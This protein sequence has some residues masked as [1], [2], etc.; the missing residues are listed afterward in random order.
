MEKYLE[1]VVPQW[2]TDIPWS[3]PN[4]AFSVRDLTTLDANN[5]EPVFSNAGSVPAID[6][7]VDDSMQLSTPKSNITVSISSHAIKNDVHL[8]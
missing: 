5:N 7:L 6:C 3:L 8:L 2:N 4:L 1:P